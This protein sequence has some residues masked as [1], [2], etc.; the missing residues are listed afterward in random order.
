MNSLSLEWGNLRDIRHIPVL[1]ANF[2]LAP[3]C[4]ADQGLGTLTK[5]YVLVKRPTTARWMRSTT[6]QQ[7]TGATRL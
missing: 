7:I 1:L 2:A 4:V 5:A 6:G 3:A